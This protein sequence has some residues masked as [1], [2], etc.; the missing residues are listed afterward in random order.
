MPLLKGSKASST[1]GVS[2]NI[3]TSMA[4]GKPQKQSV[5]IAMSVAGKSKPSKKKRP[6]GTAAERKIRAI[7]NVGKKRNKKK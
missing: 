1:K 4:E 2:A 6:K 7:G 5:A 3:S